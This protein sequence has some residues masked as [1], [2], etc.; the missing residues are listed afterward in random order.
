[1]RLGR[2]PR[3]GGKPRTQGPLHLLVGLMLCCLVTLFPL[4]VPITSEA[5]PSGA[6]RGDNAPLPDESDLLAV[7]NDVEKADERTINAALLVLL[8]LATA[9]FGAG[10]LR[11][12]KANARGRGAGCS[13]GIE[14][15]LWSG[16]A[17]EGPFFLGVF[18]L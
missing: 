4:S 1:M 11:M 17:R 9:P 7:A 3:L 13:R 10:L 15:R 16:A 12:L 18:L 5:P 6:G 14:G 2:K 8:V